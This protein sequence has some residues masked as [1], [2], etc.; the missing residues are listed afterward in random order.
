VEIDPHLFVGVRGNISGI[1][2]QEPIFSQGDSADAVF[3]IRSCKVKLTV[4]S[5]R[6]KEAAVN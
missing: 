2:G 3:Y 1:S 5:K 4:V 6:G